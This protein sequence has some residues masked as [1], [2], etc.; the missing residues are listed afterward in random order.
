[1]TGSFF[2]K[3]CVLRFLTTAS[4]RPH[5]V[6]FCKKPSISKEPSFR[7][8][9]IFKKALE[10][11]PL[12]VGLFCKSVS[13]SFPEEPSFPRALLQN[14]FNNLRTCKSLPLYCG[15][16]YLPFI[17]GSIL[18]ETTQKVPTLRSRSMERQSFCKN[19]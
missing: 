19:D 11:S 6:S 4:C 7:K 2:Q 13:H 18:L 5:R 15:H 14:E 9:S 16:V 3:S 12:I 1:M 8:S 10:K 17:V